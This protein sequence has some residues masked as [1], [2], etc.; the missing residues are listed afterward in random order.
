MNSQ[1]QGHSVAMNQG[2]EHIRRLADTPYHPVNRARRSEGSAGRRLWVPFLWLLALLSPGHAFALGASSI[3]VP[4]SIPLGTNYDVTVKLTGT[5]TYEVEVTI[6]IEGGV[7]TSPYGSSET[8]SIFIAPNEQSGTQPVSAGNEV[9][10]V[11]FVIR[12]CHEITPNSKKPC[13]DDPVSESVLAG[14]GG[15]LLDKVTRDPD[16]PSGPKSVADTVGTAHSQLAAMSNEGKN[17]TADQQDL[18]AQ[19][20]AMGGAVVGNENLAAAAEGIIAITPDQASTPRKISNRTT[21]VQL[22]NVATRLTALRRGAQGISIRN[23]TFDIDGRNIDGDT[24]TSLLEGLGAG[25]TGGGAAADDFERLGI[26]INGNIDWGEKEGSRN[27]DGFDFQTLG[28]TVGA[29]YR[30]LEGLV[31]GIAFGYGDSQVDIDAGGGNI[32]GRSWTSVLYGTYYATDHFYLEGS[33]SYGWSS[34]DQTRNI[35]YRLLGESRQAEAD[36]DG[37]QYAFMLGVGHDF[38]HG[39]GILDLYGRLRY[40]KA[41][42]D[43]Y[44]EDGARGLNLEIDSQETTSFKSTLGFNYTRSISTAKAVLAPQ[45]WLEWDHEFEAGDEDVTGRFV[46]DPTRTTFRLPTDRFDSDSLR[47][48]LGLGAQLGKGRTVFVGYETAVGLRDYMEHTV[49]LGARLEF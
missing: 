37:S 28:I 32:D 22:D 7:F 2:A 4:D 38:V 9:K 10:T 27:E 33:A 5:S 26:F 31:L 30:F 21:G 35:S 34:F 41:D 42:I 24:L 15:G 49:N 48:G 6:G 16:L 44:R 29:D 8:A 46:N 47:V 23:L 12:S 20:S 13:S 40:T 17:L 39:P 18:L 45:V 19:S 25:E 11:K 43:G 3:S 1:N 14:I 36:Y